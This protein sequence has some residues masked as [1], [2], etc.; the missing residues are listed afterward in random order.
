[1]FVS[2]C[3]IRRKRHSVRSTL[4]FEEGTLATVAIHPSRSAG[5]PACEVGFSV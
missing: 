1:M 4:G 2:T 5:R 3:R